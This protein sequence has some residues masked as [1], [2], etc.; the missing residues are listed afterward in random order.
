M[1][2]MYII[3]VLAAI[4]V[5]L[6]GF[7][8]WVLLSKEDNKP[9]SNTNQSSDIKVTSPIPGATVKSPFTV[10]GEARGTW[11]FEASFPIE[12]VD[13]TGKV[14][15]QKPVQ[16]MSDW[17]TEKFVPF[18]AILDFSSATAGPGELI[19]KKDN[20]SGLP[21]NDAEI[22]IPVM[23][24]VTVAKER[25]I[26]LFYY[27]QAQ[28]SDATGNIG[29]TEK[30][31]VAVER[32]IPWTNTPIQ[33]AVLLLLKGDLTSAERAQGISTEYPLSGF[34]LTGASVADS[35]LTLSFD[36]PNGQTGGGSC[37]VGILWMQIAATAKQF[38]GVNQ[39]KPSPE[40]L[41]QP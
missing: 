39:V 17:M 25:T 31:L 12:L 26:K 23:I 24:E 13:A 28:D 5:V 3:I 14:I 10:S 32:K 30:G 40:E 21:Q 6:G 41:F 37:R 1:K 22:R 4:I 8:A 33:D 29:C 34:A 35:V 36:D 20:P 18:M 16:A 19:L 7:L 27:S 38:G 2:K 9:I 11:F 15:A